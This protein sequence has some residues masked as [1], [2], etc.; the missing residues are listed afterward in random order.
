[1]NAGHAVWA[2]ALAALREPTTEADVAHS[3]RLPPREPAPVGPPRDRR[4][5]LD[6]ANRPLGLDVG[7]LRWNLI[8]DSGQLA[9]DRFLACYKA[10]AGQGSSTSR[11]GIW[12]RLSTSC[13][14]GDERRDID[15]ADLQRFDKYEKALLAARA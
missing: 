11:T 3:S 9:A 10:A 12:S 7:H 14:D 8:A 6:A 15:T 5:R 1:V 2:A 4:G 13:P